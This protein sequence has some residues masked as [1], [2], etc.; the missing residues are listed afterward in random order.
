MKASRSPATCLCHLQL[1]AC[2]LC[3]PH[4]LHS[5]SEVGWAF[6][7][8]HSPQWRQLPE[9]DAAAWRAVLGIR[10]KAELKFELELLLEKARADKA[11]GASLKAKVG[12]P[13]RAAGCVPKPCCCAGGAAPDAH[14]TSTHHFWAKA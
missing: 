8:S 4:A 11:L 6:P 1:T 9:A 12:R 7:T 5:S 2:G 3:L 10:F 13:A 14:V